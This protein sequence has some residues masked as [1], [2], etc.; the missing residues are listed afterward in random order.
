ML[1]AFLQGK[2]AALTEREA[3]LAMR[4]AAV[5]DREERAAQAV[6]EAEQEAKAA[7]QRAEHLGAELQAAEDEHSKASPLDHPVLHVRCRQC[8]DACA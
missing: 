4:E 1:P 3:Q 5:A 2:S 6:Q 7:L 8:C